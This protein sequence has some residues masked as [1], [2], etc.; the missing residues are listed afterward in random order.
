MSTLDQYCSTS[1]HFKSAGKHIV[2]W[3]C[4]DVHCKHLRKL[5]STPKHILALP[6]SQNTQAW[7]NAVLLNTRRSWKQA[8]EEKQNKTKHKYKE[9]NNVGLWQGGRR[10][11]NIVWYVWNNGKGLSVV[12]LR[13][14]RWARGYRLYKKK[15]A[16]SDRLPCHPTPPNSKRITPHVMDKHSKHCIQQNMM[17]LSWKKKLETMPFVSLRTQSQN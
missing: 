12:E 3:N 14:R 16:E 15:Q 11:S 9:I 5:S 17:S 2:L 8:D 13:T 4:L 1:S 10:T 6:P 7:R